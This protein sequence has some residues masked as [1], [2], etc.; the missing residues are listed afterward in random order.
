MIV[1]RTNNI[2]RRSRSERYRKSEHLLE[3]RMRRHSNQ[4]RETRKI[5]SFFARVM[6]VFLL[7]GMAYGGGQILLEKFLF[8]NPDYNVK[9]LEV[10]L[11]GVLTLPEVKK[12]THL[13]EGVNIFKLNLGAA[14]KILSDLPSVKKAH[15]ERILPNTIQ[16]SLERRLPIFRLVFSPEE[17]FVPGQSFLIDADGVAMSP[18]ELE[19][20]FLELPLL[21]GIPSSEVVLGKPI[22]EEHLLFI[23]ALWNALSSSSCSSFF[24]LHSLDISR[25]Y[26]AVVA[27][28]NNAHFVFGEENLPAQCDR[29]QKLF[30]HSQ[31]AGRQIESANLM[32]E[33][34]T[35][36][37]FRLNSD[38]ASL[39]AQN[40]KSR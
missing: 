32:L 29:L 20:S 19:S 27:D 35:P 11:D 21:V 24:T 10:S 34:N 26:C 2:N 14:E 3:V 28:A 17:E 25:G 38:A 8:K 30:A 1:R 36:V 6:F 7:L 9:H 31:S 40:K 13:Q 39:A 37:T 5:F 15:V 4:H 22:Q 16:I 23:L 33:H 18:E 12:L